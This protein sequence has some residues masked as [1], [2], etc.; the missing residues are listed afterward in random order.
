[1]DGSPALL[2]NGVLL[3]IHLRKG[4]Q[5]GRPPGPSMTCT[6][7]GDRECGVTRPSLTVT[8]S[9]ARS[10]QRITGYQPTVSF[11]WLL[12][13]MTCDTQVEICSRGIIQ[14]PCAAR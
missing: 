7:S 12:S 3:T 4:K 14:R 8:P 11:F 5:P 6:V 13:A 10:K 2:W 1:M 9:R